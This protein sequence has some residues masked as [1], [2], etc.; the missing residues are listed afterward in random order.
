MNQVVGTA[1]TST[2]EMIVLA[3]QAIPGADFTQERLVVEC[4]KMFPAAFGLRYFPQY[5]C[6]NRVLVA[7][8][9][10][11]G[12]IFLGLLC[13]TRPK[14]YQLTSAGRKLA[15]DLLARE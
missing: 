8:C 10:Q 13:R 7:L 9:Q 2:A 4:W 1:A 6:S 15:A 12:P 11:Y 5:P 14:H 3:A